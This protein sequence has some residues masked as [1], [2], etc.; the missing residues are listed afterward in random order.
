MG[1]NSGYITKEEFMSLID[2]PKV[3]AY[4]ATLDLNAE[5]AISLFRMLDEG[6][7]EDEGIDVEDFVNGCLR[8]KGPAK[9]YDCARLMS[10]VKAVSR[11]LHRQRRLME[12]A[13]RI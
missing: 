10:E 5:D 7:E 1:D 2:E 13:Y 4:F 11:E 6:S 9:S 3:Q 8:L 12:V